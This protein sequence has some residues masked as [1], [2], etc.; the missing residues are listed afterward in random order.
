MV[1]FVLHHCAGTLIQYEWVFHR[2]WELPIRKLSNGPSF[3]YHFGFQNRGATH[4]RSSNWM[5][6]RVHLHQWG[7]NKKYSVY[8]DFKLFIGSL[9]RANFILYVSF[10]VLAF[11]DG[12]SRWSFQGYI[13][14]QELLHKTWIKNLHYSY[15]RFHYWR[16]LSFCRA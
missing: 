3:G 8:H 7:T 10:I 15:R 11:D 16:N 5:F 2:T 9:L 4:L 12:G 1:N 14:I 6:G 13:F